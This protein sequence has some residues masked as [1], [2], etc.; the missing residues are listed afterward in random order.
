MSDKRLFI[1]VFAVCWMIYSEMYLAF[2]CHM[3]NHYWIRNSYTDCEVE[4]YG[5]IQKYTYHTH[6]PSNIVSPYGELLTAILSD[7]FLRH[8]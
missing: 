3:K 1:T 4:I 8:L 7:P 2:I 6:F 5:D